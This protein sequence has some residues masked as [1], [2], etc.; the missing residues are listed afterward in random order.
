MEIGGNRRLAETRQLATGDWREHPNN[1]AVL[2]VDPVAVA[3]LKSSSTL[4]LL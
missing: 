4:L 2:L 1:V 3:I